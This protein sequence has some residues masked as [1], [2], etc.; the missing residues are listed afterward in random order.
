M[1][2]PGNVE[3]QFSLF[4]DYA[5]HVKRFADLTAYH[6]THQPPCLVLWG[7]HDPFYDVDEVLDY[8]RELD[9]CEIHIFD[10]GH[11]LL[12][13]HPVECA[14]LMARFVVDNTADVPFG[15]PAQAA[16]PRDG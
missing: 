15:T 9:R 13:T 8:N 11:L 14:E 10:S 7:R 6:E 1:S 4:T 12:E 2:R 16:A 5:N 3:A